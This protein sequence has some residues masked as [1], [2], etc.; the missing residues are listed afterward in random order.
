M[1]AGNWKSWGVS[2]GVFC[3]DCEW[4]THSFRAKKARAAARSHALEETHEVM[5]R[6]VDEE[7]FIPEGHLEYKRY[8]G[9]EVTS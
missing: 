2:W 4:D 8:F 5:V 1:S 3:Q 6:E 7:S 9:S